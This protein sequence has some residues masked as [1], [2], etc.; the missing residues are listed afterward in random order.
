M[1]NLGAV[2]RVFFI[3]PNSSQFRW[4]VRICVFV[5]L[6]F[7]ENFRCLYPNKISLWIVVNHIAWMIL[8]KSGGKQTLSRWDK[9]FL[10]SFFFTSIFLCLSKCLDKSKQVARHNLLIY[11]SHSIHTQQTSTISHHPHRPPRPHAHAEDL[12][13][14][15][16]AMQINSLLSI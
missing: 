16:K 11:T 15:K 8:E 1:R 12:D 14:M 6:P 10:M 5:R 2:L 7:I 4:D 9:W 13:K 3:F